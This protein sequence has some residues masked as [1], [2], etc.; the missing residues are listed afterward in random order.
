MIPAGG[1]IE[2]GKEI[3]GLSGRGQHSGA[4]AFQRGNF[5]RDHVTGGILQTGVEIAACL[6]IKEF[7][8][9]LTGGVFEGGGLDNGNLA[10]LSVAGG[11][12]ALYAECLRAVCGHYTYISLI[13]PLSPL[14]KG[15]TQGIKFRL[16]AVCR[17]RTAILHPW[18]YSRPSCRRGTSHRQPYQNS[19][20]RSDQRRWFSPLRSPCT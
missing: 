20:C 19:P 13:M 17:N 7:A 8:H 6:Q 16:W 10:R 9:I 15:G 2:E 11:I 4:S 18:G 14:I 3:G 1:D 5:R 12:A